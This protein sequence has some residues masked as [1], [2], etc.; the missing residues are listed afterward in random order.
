MT[1]LIFRGPVFVGHSKNKNMVKQFRKER[2]TKYRVEEVPDRLLT[3]EL[4]DENNFL[5]KELI[6]YEYY[7]RILTEEEV[8][9]ANAVCNERLVELVNATSKVNKQV[10]CIRFTDSEK[11]IIDKFNHFVK[12]MEDDLMGPETCAFPAD[13][14]DMQSIIE[15]VIR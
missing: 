12:I 6:E 13:Y 14:F 5:F 1:Y 10:K 8:M 11:A 3:D 2:K 15:Y 7:G 4:Q 9:T